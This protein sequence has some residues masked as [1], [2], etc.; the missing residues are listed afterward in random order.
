MVRILMVCLGNICRSPLAEGL[1]KSKLDN[2]KY[3]VDSAGTG[4]WHIGNQPDKRSIAVANKHNL[5][6]S[7]QRGRQFSEVDFNNFDVIYAMDI[8]NYETLNAMAKSDKDKEKIK[9]FLD[10]LF[11]GE[12]ID[13]PDPYTGGIFLFEQVYGILDKATTEL[14]NQLNHA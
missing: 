6:I 7:N 11:P 10:V 1:L 4:S 13:V 5:D 8:N 3:F 12:N 9:L 14:A 2:S